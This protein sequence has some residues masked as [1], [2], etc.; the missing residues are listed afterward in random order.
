VEAKQ[1][2]ARDEVRPFTAH[3]RIDLVE[4]TTGPIG[5]ATLEPGWKNF[6]GLRDYPQTE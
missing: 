1:F 6:G 3:G 5:L 4:L 2:D